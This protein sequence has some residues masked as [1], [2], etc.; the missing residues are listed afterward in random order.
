MADD[1]SLAP[2]AQRLARAHRAGH[3]PWSPWA[4]PGAL[5]LWLALTIHVAGAARLTTWREAWIAGMSAGESIG[6]ETIQAALGELLAWAGALTLGLAVMTGMFGGVDRRAR[7]RLAIGPLRSVARGVLALVVPAVAVWLVIGV[8]AGAARAVDASPA[9]L[10][11][12]WTAWLRNLLLGTG[13]LLLAA[14]WID[15]ALARRRLWRALHRTIAE[16]RAEAKA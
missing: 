5:C 7:E 9:G 4:L 16:A 10:Q 13:G 6:W 3:R 15:R 14:G 2:D 11:G 12:L 8:C 1:G